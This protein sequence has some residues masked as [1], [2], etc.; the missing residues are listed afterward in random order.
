MKTLFLCLVWI[1]CMAP[2]YGSNVEYK[3]KHTGDFVFFGDQNPVID[4]QVFNHYRSESVRYDI[5]CTVKSDNGDIISHLRQQLSILPGDSASIAFSFYSPEPGFYK[6]LLEDGDKLIRELNVCYEPEKIY[7]LY[8]D[9]TRPDLFWDNIGKRSVYRFPQ[10]KVTRIKDERA[11][12]RDAYKVTIKC[13]GGEILQGYYFVPLKTDGVVAR[14]RL[15]Y[16]GRVDV[17]QERRYMGNTID[18]ILPVDT[19]AVKDSLFYMNTIFKYLAT[20][21]FLASRNEVEA[22]KVFAVGEGFAGGI[23]LAAS[24]IDTVRIK[25]V[26]VYN[27]FIEETGLKSGSNLFLGRIT[28][29]LKSPVLF[30]MGLQDSTAS[31]RRMFD[32]YN[33]AGSYKEYYIFPFSAKEEHPNWDALKNNFLQKFVI[34]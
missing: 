22:G 29:L 21:E 20:V 9:N 4:M 1:G 33:V 31:P 5:K 25:G 2:L 17:E 7:T 19:V 12:H 11:F 16:G 34:K 30:G 26:A 8:P 27:P 18:F 32:A 24:V 15:L 28:P 6:V 3:I 10:Y 23:A 13:S 14:A